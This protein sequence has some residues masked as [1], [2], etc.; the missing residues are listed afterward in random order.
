MR[1]PNRR[2]R[3]PHASITAAPTCTEGP[4]RPTEAPANMAQKVRG[5]FQRVCRSETRRCWAGPGG[6]DKAAITW[7]IPL[8]AA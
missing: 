2:Q 3:L 4:S 6:M 5:I 7:G 8:P 1:K